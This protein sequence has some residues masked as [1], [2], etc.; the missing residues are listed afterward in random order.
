MEGEKGRGLYL[1]RSRLFRGSL[2]RLLERPRKEVTAR[3][4][5]V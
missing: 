3:K 1:C 4:V 2:T 5:E